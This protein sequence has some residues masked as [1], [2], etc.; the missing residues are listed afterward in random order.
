MFF[1]RT[2]LMLLLVVWLGVNPIA[3]QGLRASTAFEI[4]PWT[5][6]P[7]ENDEDHGCSMSM[8]VSAKALLMVYA[9]RNE[10]FTISLR[11]ETWNFKKNDKIDGAL[12]FNGSRYPLSSIEVTNPKV[13]TLHD[14]AEEEGPESLFRKSSTVEFRLGDERIIAKLR[15]SSAAADAL[16]ACAERK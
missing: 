15:K 5:G 9:N 14:G 16:W 13:L 11:N 7:V 10:A 3:A 8:K 6:S 12:L 1:L 4:G 2:Q